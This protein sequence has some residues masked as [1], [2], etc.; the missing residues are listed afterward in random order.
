MRSNSCARSS[1]LRIVASMY[2]SE[3]PLYPIGRSAS[4][5]VTTWRPGTSESPL[6]NVVMS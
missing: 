5:T 6:A 2:G 3:S 4:G 1:T